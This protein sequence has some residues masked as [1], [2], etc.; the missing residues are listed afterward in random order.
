[1]IGNSRSNHLDAPDLSVLNQKGFCDE[2]AGG[3]VEPTECKGPAI[4]QRSGI[5]RTLI[6]NN[7][8]PTIPRSWN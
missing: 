5:H 1:M 2:D 3:P 4:R 8:G 6:K 7:V